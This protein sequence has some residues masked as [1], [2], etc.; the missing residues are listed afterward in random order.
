MTYRERDV[1]MNIGK[2]RDN[3]DKDGKLKCFNY[4]TYG[5]M[6]KNC[7]KPKKERDTRKYYKYEKIGH[8]VKDCRL[9]QKIKNH[10]IQ[11]KSDTENN[12][13]EQGFGDS[14]E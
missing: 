6:I 9:E 14:P 5:Y 7:Q 2:T 11:K 8:I 10:S 1:P 12:D 3:F 4:N 13:K